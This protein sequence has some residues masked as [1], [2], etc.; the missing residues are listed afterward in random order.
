MHSAHGMQSTAQS[1]LCIS[2]ART[3]HGRARSRKVP[4][5]QKEQR[6]VGTVWQQPR[7]GRAR[8]SL[9]GCHVLRQTV[10]GETNAEVHAASRVDSCPLT[11][12][13]A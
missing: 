4:G 6:A 10:P 7:A 8:L 11:Q 5:T 1:P 2:P 12:P 13:R 3:P 9:H